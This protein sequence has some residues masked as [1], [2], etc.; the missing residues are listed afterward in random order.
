MLVLATE[1]RAPWLQGALALCKALLTGF[2]AKSKLGFVE[3]RTGKVPGLVRMSA[4]D[5]CETGCRLDVAHVRDPR[6]SLRGASR[7]SGHRLSRRSASTRWSRSRWVT[8]RLRVLASR[9]VGLF[10]RGV[11][12][13]PLALSLEGCYWTRY[14]VATVPACALLGPRPVPGLRLVLVRD[15]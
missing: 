4:L 14:R 2:L 6:P 5:T 7:V 1:G 12:Q 8:V 15:A 11:V 10:P 9:R 3:D 13:R